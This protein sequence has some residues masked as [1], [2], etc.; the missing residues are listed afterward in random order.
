MSNKVVGPWMV[1]F[2][3][4]GGA[5]PFDENSV[6]KLIHTNI[7]W[8]VNLFSKNKDILIDD[9]A[10]FDGPPYNYFISTRSSYLPV[11]CNNGDRKS[12]V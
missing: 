5:K 11:R 9:N 6:Q 3:G 8:D 4:E 1:D 7:S 2:S 12:V 10:A